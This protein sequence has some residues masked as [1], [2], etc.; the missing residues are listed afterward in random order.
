MN[1]CSTHVFIV[2][3][4][5]VIV[6]CSQL[7]ENLSQLIANWLGLFFMSRDNRLKA[8]V[9]RSRFDDSQIINASLNAFSGPSNLNYV[10]PHIPHCLQQC[11]IL[12]H[13]YS[14]TLCFQKYHVTCVIG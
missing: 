13:V 14:N 6:Y 10:L 11:T 8:N 7:L 4:I 9:V 3:K 12:Y 1:L 5:I 2:F